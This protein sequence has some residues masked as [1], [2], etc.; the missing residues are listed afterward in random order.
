MILNTATGVLTARLLGAEGRG[1]QAAMIIWQVLFAG[2]FSFGLPSSLVYNLNARVEEQSK[3]F[4]AAILI[5][6]LLG[7]VAGLIGFILLPS[8][9]T[10]YSPRVVREA[11]F[12]MIMTPVALLMLICRA[13]LEARGD[14][15]GSNKLL[16]LI[17]LTTLIGLL[18]LVQAK[19]F[20][21]FNSALVY[22]FAG[23]PIFIRT[24]VVLWRYYL[25][26]LKDFPASART[27][28]N[29]GL[30]I[31]GADLLTVLATQIDQVL[32]I[33]L[34]SPD[35]MGMYIVALNLSRV[36][37]VVQSSLVMV[38]FTNSAGQPIA[39]VIKQTGQAARIGVAITA[40]A[41]LAMMA[42]GGFVLHVLYGG[43][44]TNAALLL[45]ILIVEAGFTGTTGI[46]TT[47][48]LALDKPGAVTIV[49]AVGL[50]V[51]VSLL[52]ILIPKYGMYGVSI[53][54]LCASIVRFAL[55]RL[56]FRV[57]LKIPAPSLLLKREDFLTLRRALFG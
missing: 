51:L 29:F 53:A 36:L 20:T 32:I 38:L 16:L 13:T 24:F 8:W 2:M 46:L 7:A 6:S 56:C 18:A 22:S 35:A 49:Q 31:Y 43:E 30:R 10:Q 45:N 34:L 4:G 33:G 57:L 44:F 28:L 25:P 5:G 12:L 50:A 27:L 23:L 11:Q 17:P 47:G 9:L 41:S 26:S 14:Y 21:P 37:W 48:F 54:L 42:C 40:T 55:V 1:E 52:L 15:T 3:L 19:A 39:E